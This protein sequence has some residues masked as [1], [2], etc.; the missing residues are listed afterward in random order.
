MKIA[1]GLLLAVST[2][3]A[4]DTNDTPM[5]TS[6]PRKPRQATIFRICS[7]FNATGLAREAH[8]QRQEPRAAAG[9]RRPAGRGRRGRRTDRRGMP[10]R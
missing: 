7:S 5:R 9:Q 8:A 1:L 3:A 4:Q 6:P 10:N 2:L